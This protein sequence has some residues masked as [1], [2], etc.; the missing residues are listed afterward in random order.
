MHL[1]ETSN[2]F[3]LPIK[4][5]VR[6][7]SNEVLGWEGNE[8]KVRLKAIPEKGEANTLLIEFLAK[9]LGISK[10]KIELLAGHT[11]RHKRLFITGLTAELLLSKYPVGY[12]KTNK[13]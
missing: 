1:K 2:G 3:E 10:S 8:L 7:S 13:K 4:V 12:S 5:T 6:A 11:S 9:T